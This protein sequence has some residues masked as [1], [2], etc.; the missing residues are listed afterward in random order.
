MI[1]SLVDFPKERPV[2]LLWSGL[3]I[4]FIWQEYQTIKNQEPKIK[5]ASWFVYILLGISAVGI[6][7]VGK[8]AQSESA[9]NQALH[10][11]SQQQYIAALKY[12]N[13]ANNWT[14]ELD[15]AST[16]LSWYIGEA[17]FLLN[18][19][20]Q[21]LEAF[22]T[23]KQLHPYHLHT[24]NNLG[25]TYFMLNNLEQAQ[26]YF[27]QVLEWA[28]HFPD[29]NMNMGA[30]SYNQGNIPEAV[31]YIG[32]CV[33]INYQDPRFVQFLDA[34]IKSYANQLKENPNFQVIH[35]I[36]SR[37]NRSKEWQGS[38]HQNA[39]K[40]KRSLKEQIHLDVLYVAKDENY[41]QE[42]QSDSLLQILNNL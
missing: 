18:Q 17:H 29:A 24:I 12:L 33:P 35:P 13:Q 1:F 23:A 14:Y 16:P 36:L 27:K 11:R 5:G 41:I 25:A 38:I 4:A 3:L 28:P 9:C 19:H 22:E 8:R 32:A 34:I 40:H 2:H 42:S 6:F 39:Q 31:Q 21:A 26:N 7:F 30:I 10:A 37:L 20:Q 15:P